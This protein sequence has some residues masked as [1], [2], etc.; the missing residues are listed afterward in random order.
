MW[1]VCGSSTLL[2]FPD[3]HHLAPGWANLAL[4]SCEVGDGEVFILDHWF[5][6]HYC[7]GSCTALYTLLP[8]I[9]AQDLEA[10]KIVGYLHCPQNCHLNN[11]EMG[12]DYA[13]V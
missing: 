1:L 7:Y 4:G 5:L 13:L 2:F 12:L 8:S 10:A 11:C 6:V 9:P 3:D